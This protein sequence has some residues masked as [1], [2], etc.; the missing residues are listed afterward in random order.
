MSEIDKLIKSE[1]KALDSRKKFVSSEIEVL[2]NQR[3]KIL[4]DAEKS[5]RATKQACDRECIKLKNEAQN[6]RKKAQELLST[7]ETR[8]SDTLVIQDQVKALD[9]QKKAFAEEKKN[10]ASAKT[11]SL[12]DQ[13][14]AKLLI[15]QYEKKLAELGSAPKTEKKKA[16][17]K[18]PSKKV[19]K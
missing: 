8:D 15:E 10:A 11:K 19:K 2:V 1:L 13:K 6:I 7:A 12:T 14:K 9:E 17:K 5:A 18:K 3:D 16:A 4:G